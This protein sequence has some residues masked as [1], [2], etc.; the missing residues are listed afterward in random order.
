MICVGMMN[1]RPLDFW[2]LS[3]RELYLSIKGF[4]KF[5]GSETKEQPMDSSRLQELMEL[6]PD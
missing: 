3:P 2:E 5:N 6:N 4:Q 1:M